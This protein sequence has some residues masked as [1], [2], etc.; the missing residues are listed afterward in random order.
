MLERLFLPQSSFSTF[1]QD[2]VRPFSSEQ[3]RRAAQRGGELVRTYGAMNVSPREFRQFKMKAQRYLVTNARG[4]LGSSPELRDDICGLRHIGATPKFLGPSPGGFRVRGLPRNPSEQEFTIGKLRKYVEEGGMFVCSPNGIPAGTEFCCSHSTTDAKMPGRTISSDK[5]RIW[6]GRRVNLRCH[7][8]DYWQLKTPAIG[9]SAVRFCQIRTSSPCI[10]FIGAKTNIEVAVAR[11]RLRPE[12]DFM[13][14]TEFDL[15][16]NRG[17]TISFFYIALPLGFSG[18]SGIS[19]RIMD[20]VQICHRSQPD[21]C[22]VWG[23]SLPSA[24]DIFVADG[25]FPDASI[26]RGH[27]KSAEVWGRRGD[28]FFGKCAISTKKLRSA[29][30]RMRELP[31]TGPPRRFP[32]RS[33][34]LSRPKGVRRR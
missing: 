3:V 15:D 31:H 9:G 26:G 2:A 30:T 11:C 21:A 29:G 27:I 5:R 16:C 34:F 25:M 1:W 7:K 19:G 13:F 20:A 18:P 17:D 8:Y 28:L 24:A 23:D 10:P 12:S 6:D 14:G 33:Y 22:P 32:E 4:Y